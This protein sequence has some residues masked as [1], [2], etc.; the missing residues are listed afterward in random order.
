MATILGNRWQLGESLGVGAKVM[1]F[2]HRIGRGNTTHPFA[3][4]AYS[5]RL[6]DR[7]PPPGRAALYRNL[8]PVAPRS[9]QRSP[10]VLPRRMMA[11]V[12]AV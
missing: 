6:F 9:P 4:L 5:R 7:P 8:T 3:R 10:L 1:C 12:H 11:V 2:T